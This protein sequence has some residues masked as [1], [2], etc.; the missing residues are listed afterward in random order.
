MIVS[1]PKDLTLTGCRRAAIAGL[2]SGNSVRVIA[3]KLLRCG[4]ESRS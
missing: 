3:I 4:I 1:G 2:L